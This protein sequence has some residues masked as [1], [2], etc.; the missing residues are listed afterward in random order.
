M[1]GWRRP[2]R[3]CK[4]IG[5]VADDRIDDGVD[6]QRQHDA[7][8][9]PRLRQAEHLVVVEEQEEREAVVLDAEGDGAE[10]VEELGGE[11]DA[12]AQADR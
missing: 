1:N 8:A 2:Q 11:V 5:E 7:E 10:A 3:E 12:Q 9:D 4:M 6:H